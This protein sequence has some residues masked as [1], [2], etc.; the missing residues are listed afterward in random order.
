M[1]PFLFNWEKSNWLGVLI[2]HYPLPITHYQKDYW[3]YPPDLVLLGF[4]FN[5]AHASRAVPL[6]AGY[7]EA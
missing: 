4:A 1:T 7:C 5:S 2:T 3:V 6:S